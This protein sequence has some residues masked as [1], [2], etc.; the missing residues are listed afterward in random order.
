[1]SETKINI[2]ELK[3]EGSDLIQELAAFLNEKTKTN[4][5]TTAED[6]VI[7]DENKTIPRTTLRL[8]LK[9]FLHK[10]ELRE[11]YRVIGGKENALIIKERKTK[12]EE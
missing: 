5:E 6:I 12:E 1:M 2:T 3:T 9:K 10:K 11:Y 8:L 7:K 4:A